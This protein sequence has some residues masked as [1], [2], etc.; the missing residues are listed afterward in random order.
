HVLLFR[1]GRRCEDCLG[2]MPLPGVTHGCYRND[3]AAIVVVAAMLLVNRLRR[4][5]TRMVDRYI[6]LTEAGLEK[7]VAAG[8]P[9][10]K[11]SLK[12]NFVVTDPGSG[13]HS[14]GYA[15]YVGRLSAE[16]GIDTLLAAWRSMGEQS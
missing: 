7:F 9:R 11:I 16:K 1:D 5:W 2:R 4:T 3:R 15:M 10:E 13:D 8:L 14:G 12:P 6:A